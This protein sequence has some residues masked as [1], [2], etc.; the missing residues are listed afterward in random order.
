MHRLAGNG[1]AKGIG[2]CCLNWA[3]ER[4]K[5]LRVDTHEDNVVLQSLLTKLGFQYCGII[6]VVQDSDPRLAY[7]KSLD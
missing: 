2:A 1:A 6:Y 3:L 7:E 4:S 5:H